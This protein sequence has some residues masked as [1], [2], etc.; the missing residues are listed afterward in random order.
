MAIRRNRG[1]A[2][3][4]AARG[5]NSPAVYINTTRQ[6]QQ[7][8]LPTKAPQARS[9]RDVVMGN[10]RPPPV[11][12]GNTRIFTSKFLCPLT[13]LGLRYSIDDCN[14]AVEVSN[15]H[16]RN[17]LV[18]RFGDNMVGECK[19]AWQCLKESSLKTEFE[20]KLH[21][22]GSMAAAWR[23]VM[24]WSLR[25]GS[26]QM[27]SNKDPELFFSK[28]DTLLNTLKDVGVHKDDDEF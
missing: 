26:C 10:K 17:V 5:E 21:R 24:G 22:A 27:M 16:H 8:Q 25:L 23:V 20:E 2:G 14:S 7:Q 12:E 11:D 28:C 13:S 9:I 18:E 4:A 1:Q 6:Q 19:M 15:C 3:P